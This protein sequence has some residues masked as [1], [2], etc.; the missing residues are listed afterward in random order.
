MRTFDAIA[1][2]HALA[3][4]VS[5]LRA[6]GCVFAEDEAQL[7][8]AEAPDSESLVEWVDS[9]ISGMPLEYILGWADFCGERIAVDPGVFV[10]RRRTELLVHQAVSLLRDRPSSPPPVV[11]D[12]CCGSG[13]VGTAIARLYPEAELHSADI[14][15]AAVNCARRNV[16]AVGGR[17]YQGDLFAA[18]PPGLHGRVRILAVNAPYVPTEAIRTMPPEARLY[19]S[20]AALDGGD[21][22]L[23]FH[24]RVAADALEWLLPDG[25]LLIETSRQQAGR[26]AGIVA[27]AGFTVCTVHSDELE[28]TVVVGSPQ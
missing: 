24:H 1:A 25:H 23:D 28:G 15:H 22:G 6:A 3:P 27:G 26:T 17:V 2:P 8:V 10:P 11:V 19:E 5:A 13:A 18:L 7:L 16:D 12:L 20:R 14:D 4:I 21:D 9:R